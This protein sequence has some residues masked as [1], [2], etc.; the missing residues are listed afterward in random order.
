MKTNQTSNYMWLVGVVLTLSV[1]IRQCAVQHKKNKFRPVLELMHEQSVKEHGKFYG[2][3][4]VIY[5]LSNREKVNAYYNYFIDK[6]YTD[7]DSI[8]FYRIILQTPNNTVTIGRDTAV[9]Q[10]TGLMLKKELD[11]SNHTTK[12]I[13]GVYF[14][15]NTVN[16]VE[17]HHFFTSLELYKNDSTDICFVI[18]TFTKDTASHHHQLAKQ[19]LQKIKNKLHKNHGFDTSKFKVKAHFDYGLIEKVIEFRHKK[20][21]VSTKRTT[22]SDVEY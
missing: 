14:K 22:N 17:K 3:T 7:T 18:D 5:T 13:K 8:H 11:T 16:Y 10:A 19:R 12:E 9:G 15:P 21:R 4:G 20:Q 6:K 1:V 2:K